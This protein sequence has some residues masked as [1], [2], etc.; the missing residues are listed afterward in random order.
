MREVVVID[1]VRTAV[2]KRNGSLAHTHTNDLLGNVL[3]TVIQRNGLDV[4]LVDQVVGGCV[5]QL[6]MQAANAIRNAWLAAGLPLQTPAVTVNAQCGSSQ[7]ATRIA[8]AQIAGGLADVVIACGVESMS[9]VVIGSNAPRGGPAGMPR[10]G[11]YAERWEVTTQFE[12]ADRIA[13]QWKISRSDLDEFATLSQDRAAQA[14]AEHRFDG[15]IVPIEVPVLDEAGVRIDGR[16]FERDEGPRATSLDALSGLKA[17]QPDR[18]PPG[19]HTAATSSQIADGAC[20][21][22]LMSREKAQELGLRARARIVASVLVGSDP[23]LMLTGPIPATRE[24]LAQSDLGLEDIDLFEINEAFGAVV[25]AWARETGADLGKVNVNGGAI[26]L[27]HPL[28]ATGV[29]LI[30]K[31]LYELER[32]GGRY[33]LVSMC[34]GGGLGT[35][36]IIERLR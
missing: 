16:A 11:T 9:N 23:V 27:G 19:R 17:N 7:E 31:L 34:C 12:G 20:A 25:L 13:E 6:G 28:G 35:G 30:T 36:T 32:T 1:A 18:V 3:A 24:L 33:G 15:Q 21:V 2:G 26:A 22:L 4:A 10:E 5:T 8:H 14:L 29:I